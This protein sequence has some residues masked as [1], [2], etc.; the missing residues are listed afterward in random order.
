MS[1]PFLDLKT[2][3]NQIKDEIRSELTEVLDTCYYVLGPKVAAF[4]EKFA[5]IAGTKY[6]VAVSSGTAAVHIMIW[7]SDLQPGSGIIVPPNTFTASVEGI[8]LAGHVPVFVDVD[9]DTLNLSPDRVRSFLESC[10]STG[11]PIDPKTGAEIR[12]ILAVDLYGQ[13]AAMPELEEISE[14]YGLLLFEDACQSVN[15]SRNGRPAGSFG[16]VAAFSFYPGKNLGAFGEGGAVTT[17]S[18]DIAGRVRALRDHGSREKYIYDFIGH[19]YRMSAFQGA[20]LGVKSR[21]ISQWNDR[22]RDSAKRYNELLSGL[23]LVLPSEDGNVRH[24]Y[25]LYAVHT[26]ERDTLREFLSSR[27]VASGL[28][29]P[30]PLH[31]QKAYSYLGYEAGDFPVSEWNSSCNLTLPMFPD[32]TPD[33]QIIV[34][35]AVKSYFS[36]KD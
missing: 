5:E 1:V 2:Q 12:G 27:D 23:P 15:A 24:V 7:A 36:E 9:R 19:N 6:C 26:P 11:K 25:H 35:E 31:T 14:H 20:V 4:E 22:R 18:E 29:Y 13:P 8:V 10:S 34:T 33:Q 17:N 28:H 21:Y 3:Y 30:L 16:T 32:L